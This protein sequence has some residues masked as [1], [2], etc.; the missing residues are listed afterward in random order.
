ME[1][2]PP[3]MGHTNLHINTNHSDH[4]KYS[5]GLGC[6][7]GVFALLIIMIILLAVS[8]HRQGQMLNNSNNAISQMNTIKKSV[9]AAKGAQYMRN[10]SGGKTRFTNGLQGSNGHAFGGSIGSI[11]PAY[12]GTSDGGSR[13][14]MSNQFGEQIGTGQGLGKGTCTSGNCGSYDSGSIYSM[15]TGGGGSAPTNESQIEL[16]MFQD[17][18]TISSDVTIQG[19]GT[20]SAPQRPAPQRPAPQRPAPQRSAPQR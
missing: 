12:W 19:G 7:I 6:F 11:S 13:L 1:N 10:M 4:D 2:S 9:T 5:M 16:N 8:A 15:S 18:G 20:R 3:M 17:M 14:A